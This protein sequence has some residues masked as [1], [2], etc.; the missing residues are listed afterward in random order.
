MKLTFKEKLIKTMTYS[1]LL[2]SFAQPILGITQVAAAP[3]QS[4]TV[5]SIEDS[6]E[7]IQNLLIEQ[8]VSISELIELINIK[9][10]EVLILL[11][12][13][14]AKES[15][16]VELQVEIDE[17]NS[18]MLDLEAEIK[19]T[20]DTLNQK[21]EEYNVNIERAAA[22]ALSLQKN[23]KDKVTMY[24]DAV[25][26]SESL[27]DVLNRVW[28]VNIILSAHEKQIYN[29]EEQ[30]DAINALKL[31]L[32][33]DKE[34]LKENQVELEEMKDVL[35]RD[36]EDL[37]IEKEETEKVIEELDEQR[38]EIQESYEGNLNDLY[39]MQETKDGQKLLNEMLANETN[40]SNLEL[41]SGSD[42]DNE[43]KNSPLSIAQSLN[44]IRQ[45]KRDQDVVNAIMVEA[46]KY[47]GVPYVWGGTTPGGFDC[48]GFTQYIF[49][50]VGIPLQRTS[51]QQAVAGSPVAIAE[52][53]PGDLLFWDRNGDVYH[54]A[55]YIG[56]GEY[57]HA[58]RPGKSVSVGNVKYFTPSS[59]RR[60]IPN[61]TDGNKVTA[62]PDSKKGDLI[63]T[64]QSTAYAVGAW[65]VPGTVTANGTDI[66]KTILS[67]EGHRI[68]AVDTKVIPMNSV[69]RVE[70]P[71][72][73][74]FNA[75]ASDTGGAI[76][77][78]IIDILFS[79]PNEAR[80]FGRKNGI[81]VYKTN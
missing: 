74:P 13:L 56:G 7:G 81:K 21:I 80:Q 29:I 67:P 18:E 72:M 65:G 38:K 15:E 2:L 34:I 31:G 49:N 64:F 68:I 55:L 14:E 69:V 45:G 24:I 61:G 20:T 48:S 3:T 59:A 63:G 47:M 73:K 28:G 33:K 17:L 8:D 30:A 26:N 22:R 62:S 39:R 66:S 25:F 23:Q 11:G 43:N 77:G 54:V 5:T 16:L 51:R 52:A 46:N 37:V 19:E 53:Q 58:P 36:S 44:E 6:I 9:E 27:V 70:V 4:G 42:S 32:D 50:D 35:V 10:E 79:T 71:G 12:E 41:L 60:V 78:N 76:K 57:I 1:G 40:Q 75:K